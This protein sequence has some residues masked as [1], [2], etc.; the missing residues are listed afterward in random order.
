VNSATVGFTSF[1]FWL[2]LALIVIAI[3]W[4]V[5]KKLQMRH[6]LTLKL[7]ERG[8]DVDPELLARLLANDN[9]RLQK[10][11]AEQHR[12]QGGLTYILFTIAGLTLVVVGI[13]RT[14]VSWPL[15]GLGALTFLYGH[16]SWLQTYKE[17][18]RE[19]AEEKSSRD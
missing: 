14:P 9:P 15:L 4:A 7:L 16:F 8:Q 18:L 5:I 13:L 12:D 3:I 11:V 17:Y 2:A 6:T 1:G 10:S 19:K